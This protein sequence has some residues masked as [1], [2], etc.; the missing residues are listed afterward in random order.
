MIFA[1]MGSVCECFDRGDVGHTHHLH[2]PLPGNDPETGMP[3]AKPEA[4][5]SEQE[6]I[7]SLNT[8]APC[9]VDVSPNF[10]FKNVKNKDG[11]AE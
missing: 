1:R 4:A 5:E 3:P 6:E 7:Q 11:Q 9:V 10:I 2:R 8:Q